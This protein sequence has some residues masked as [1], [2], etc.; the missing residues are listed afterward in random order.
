MLRNTDVKASIETIMVMLLMS[1]SYTRHTWQTIAAPWT[2]LAL[3]AGGERPL[4]TWCAGQVVACRLDCVW[5]TC[6]E[7]LPVKRRLL[8]GEAAQALCS[9]VLAHHGSSCVGGA[10]AYMAASTIPCTLTGAINLQHTHRTCW[11]VYRVRSLPQPHCTHL[12]CTR[13]QQQHSRPDSVACICP[14]CRRCSTSLEPMGSRM[15]IGTCSRVR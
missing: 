6:L 14:P 1:R 9:G 8:P 3:I 12:L 11:Y 10:A 13:H 5:R 2:V 7:A 15:A 4:R